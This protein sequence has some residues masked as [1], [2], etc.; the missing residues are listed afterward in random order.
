MPWAFPKNTPGGVAGEPRPVGAQPCPNPLV[1]PVPAG[2]QLL[3]GTGCPQGG[4]ALG[5]NMVPGGGRRLPIFSQWRIPVSC[6][7]DGMMMDLG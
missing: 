7:T 4:A 5:R 2:W 3:V 6:Y 1:A